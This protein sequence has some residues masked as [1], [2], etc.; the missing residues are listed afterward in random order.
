MTL[1]SQA[2]KNDHRELEDAYNKILSATTSDEKCRWQNQF[3]W[4]LARHSIG[5]ELLVYPAL[6]SNL[7]DGK[8][9]ADKDRAEHQEVSHMPY[10]VRFYTLLNMAR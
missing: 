9:L 4:E 10:Q 1:I 7:P 3:T 6:E 5:E 8:Q 2:I